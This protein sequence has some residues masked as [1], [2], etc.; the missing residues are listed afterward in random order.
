[1]VWLKPIKGH[2][3]SCA[4]ELRQ[5]ISV[6]NFVYNIEHLFIRNSLL[7]RR[8]TSRFLVLQVMP[9]PSFFCFKSKPD[10]F[11]FFSDDKIFIFLLHVILNVP[12]L[13]ARIC[14]TKILILRKNMRFRHLESCLGLIDDG[15][16]CLVSF[17]RSTIPPARQRSAIFLYIRFFFFWS[18]VQKMDMSS[19]A[20]TNPKPVMQSMMQKDKTVTN[21]LK[22]I[23]ITKLTSSNRTGQSY[24]LLFVKV[25]CTWLFCQIV[26]ENLS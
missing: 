23:L 3:M 5:Q 14:S 20:L 16:Y 22:P 13:S 12:S 10:S 19:A 21:S 7:A 1:M 15:L 18:L 4:R 25:C 11:K 2:T 6:W 8:T 26:R 17:L 24:A 9:R